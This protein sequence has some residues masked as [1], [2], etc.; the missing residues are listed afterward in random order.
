MNDHVKVRA[1]RTHFIIRTSQFMLFA[2]GLLTSGFINDGMATTTEA[3]VTYKLPRPIVSEAQPLPAS[4][5][6]FSAVQ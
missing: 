3:S 5:F 6:G 4:R 2:A 1:R